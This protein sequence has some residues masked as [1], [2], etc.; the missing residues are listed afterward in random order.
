MRDWVAYWEHMYELGREDELG[1][2]GQEYL[3]EKYGEEF[4]PDEPPYDEYDYDY[5][6]YDFDIEY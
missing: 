5:S 3:R 1:P 6:D 4:T 2:K